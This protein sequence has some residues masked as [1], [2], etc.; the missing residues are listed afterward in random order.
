MLAAC[1]REINLAIVD[2]QRRRPFKLTERLV[3]LAYPSAAFTISLAGVCDGIVRD[4]I[5]LQ[6]LASSSDTLGQPLKFRSYQSILSERNNWARTN[7]TPD[8][9]VEN[10]LQPEANS[11]HANYTSLNHRYDAFVVNNQLGLYPK[12]T[13]ERQLMLMVHTW[14]PLLVADD[15]TNFFLTFCYDYILFLAL[16]RMH[17]FMKVDTRY[18][19]TEVHLE[20]LWK[21][22]ET[23]DGSITEQMPFTHA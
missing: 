9:Y 13:E 11:G 17:L 22:I 20:K 4:F 2:T 6:L 21:D 23:W 18:S 8:I 7:T 5:G 3:T 16:Q 14:L 12:P 1:K 19:V 15:D 10:P